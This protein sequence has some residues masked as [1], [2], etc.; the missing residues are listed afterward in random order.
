MKDDEVA[1]GADEA[2]RAFGGG[3]EGR[4]RIGGDEGEAG[5]LFG[6][7]VGGKLETLFEQGLDHLGAFGGG[8]VVAGFGDDIEALGCGPLGAALDL[9]GEAGER[10]D[11]LLEGDVEG[12]EAAGRDVD[13][14]VLKD[15]AG[16]AELD[17]GDFEVERHGLGG[18]RE[19]GEQQG[20]CWG[21]K[22]AAH[23]NW[24][25]QV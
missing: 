9:L 6:F 15:R 23:A 16:L 13:A 22:E 21:D 24:H 12:F 25:L 20:R 14:H 17:G 10:R 19:R 4:G 18:D 3:F 11:Q 8:D 7:A 2:A 1:L 5:G